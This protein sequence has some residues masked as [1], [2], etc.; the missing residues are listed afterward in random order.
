MA[1]LHERVAALE[2]SAI[3]HDKQIKAIRD[4]V[5]VGMRLMVETRKEMAEN[6]KD[7]RALAKSVQQLTNSLQRGPNGHAK[8]KIDFE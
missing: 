7:L 8:R 4:L 2:R 5:Q 1:A 6:R 3:Q